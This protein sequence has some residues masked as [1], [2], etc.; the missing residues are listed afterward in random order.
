MAFTTDQAWIAADAELGEGTTVG[1][2]SLVG[3]D[4]PG[5]APPALG[6]NCTLR[7][8]SVIYR[9]TRIGDGFQT[10]HGA[11]VR[12]NVTIGTGVSLGTHSS[13]E[14][15]TVVED[16][17][18]IH[19]HCFIPEYVTLRER[20]WI[21]PR[22]TILNAMHP[23]CPEFEKCGQGIAA[24]GHESE[25][26]HGVEIGAGAKIGGGVVI[27]PWVRVGAGA[28]VGAGAVVT[29]DVPAGR[30]VAGN[31][32]RDRGPVTD[33]SCRAG[34]FKTPYEWEAEHD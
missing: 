20:C 12:E 23:P 28:L 33:L 19:G 14:R 27:G 31:P 11:M 34:Y 17:V 2:W 9:G 29:R 7:S 22:V 10:G 3:R 5:A 18:R 1:P 6:A 4:P 24:P 8:H 15:D 25:R 32:A 21:G 26:I 13:I 16:G 30:V